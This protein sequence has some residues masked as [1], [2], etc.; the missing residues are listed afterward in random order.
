MPLFIMLSGFLLNTNKL[1]NLNIKELINKYLFRVIIPWCFAVIVYWSC[2]N[3][4]LL[5]SFKALPSILKWYIIPYYH[6]WFI[7]SFLIWIFM[8]WF[9]LKLNVSIN[10]ILLIGSVISLI[11]YFFRLHPETYSNVSSNATIDMV[12]KKYGFHFYI[13][14]V[15]GIYFKNAFKST[16]KKKY[17]I[18]A[19]GG[20]IVNMCLF[21]YPNTHLSYINYFVFNISFGLIV[22]FLAKKKYFRT[23]KYIEWMGENSMGI[24]L[25][26]ILPILLSKYL[27]LS[28]PLWLFYSASIVLQC[29]FILI[30][31]FLKKNARIKKYLFGL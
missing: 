20:I 8:T 6:L 26:H 9:L 3:Y 29:A 13:F 18:I 5:L 24:Y 15:A 23:Q 12:L 10:R 17:Y 16:I 19:L 27:F 11:W 14:F 28:K 25:W 4:E 22:L 1:Q 30:Y 2:K 7:P 31:S 21:F